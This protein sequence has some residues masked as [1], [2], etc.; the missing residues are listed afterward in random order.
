M[1][2]AVDG[3]EH[4]DQLCDSHAV[5]LAPQGRRRS[6]ADALRRLTRKTELAGELRSV[7]NILVAAATR[8]RVEGRRL[9]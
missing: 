1:R 6:T 3:R 8:A 7:L 9:A 5:F 2:R 4:D